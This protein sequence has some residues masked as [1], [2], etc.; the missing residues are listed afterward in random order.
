MFPDKHD[1]QFSRKFHLLKTVVHIFYWIYNS[2]N[3]T[4][5]LLKLRFNNN[6]IKVNFKTISLL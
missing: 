2:E 1:F 5:I 4:E 6:E 3:L